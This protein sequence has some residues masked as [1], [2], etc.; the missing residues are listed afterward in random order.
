M[1][2]ILLVLLVFGSIS[3]NAQK[4]AQATTAAKAA[5]EVKAETVVQPAPAPATFEVAVPTTKAK[6]SFET[7]TVDYGTIAKDSDPLRV[8]KFTNTG[9]E[10]LVIT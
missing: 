10:P 1:K 6:M 8:V 3:I 4:K 5:T 9:T 2:Q 7:L